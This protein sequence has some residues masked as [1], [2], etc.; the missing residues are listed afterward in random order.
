MDRANRAAT[1][2]GNL[3][4]IELLDRATHGAFH[5][6][7]SL[8]QSPV[9]AG[10]STSGN[11]LI[12]RIDQAWALV[13]DQF[14]ELLELERSTSKSPTSISSRSNAPLPSRSPA[15]NQ[16]QPTSPN[17]STVARSAS[18]TSSTRLANTSTERAWNELIHE[19]DSW[20]EQRT[21]AENLN[22]TGSRRTALL[23]Q[24]PTQAPEVSVII[25]SVGRKL[26]I[27]DAIRSSLETF[28]SCEIITVLADGRPYDFSQGWA[29]TRDNLHELRLWKR[30]G[31]GAAVR[32]GLMQAIGEYVVIQPSHRTLST[33][34]MES[35]LEP[36]RQG[37]AD[38]TILSQFSRDGMPLAEKGT[39][40]DRCGETLIGWSLE[41]LFDLPLTHA[42][43]SAKAIRGSMLQDL[44]IRSRGDGAIVDLLLELQKR[45]A[46]FLEVPE[47]V[48]L[49]ERSSKSFMTRSIL[50]SSLKTLIR[51]RIAA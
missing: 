51:R 31:W 34:A 23:A 25:P 39:W 21:R 43:G 45:R 46:R 17:A 40:R 19:V 29:Q 6:Q 27:D 14:A 33:N 4:G 20:E 13:S 24:T 12:E 49:G 44:V 9:N 5:D 16:D 50:W 7:P 37:W 28:P 30:Q 38:V 2:E 32:I 36:L 47:R 1:R 15:R 26:K 11:E 10:P 35:L 18:V 8:N 48:S 22:R 41:Q 42:L 3:S